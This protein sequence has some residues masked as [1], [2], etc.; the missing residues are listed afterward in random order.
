MVHCVLVRGQA[1]I[2]QN[3]VD[4]QVMFV[5]MNPK[6]SFPIS[7]LSMYV[8]NFQFDIQFIYERAVNSSLF[9]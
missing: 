6:C 4:G 9:Q 7:T 1:D 8:H 5:V 2:R 3:T